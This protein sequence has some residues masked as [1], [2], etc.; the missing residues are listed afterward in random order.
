MIAV[1]CFTGLR[2]LVLPILWEGDVLGRVV[3]GPFVPEEL[4]DLPPTLTDLTP[5]IDLAQAQSYLA[6]IRRAPEST[7]NHTGLNSRLF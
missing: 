1:P 3:F 7:I 5:G 2:Y 4:G 6:K